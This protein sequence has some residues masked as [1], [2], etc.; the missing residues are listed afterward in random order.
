LFLRNQL[1]RDA[2]WSSMAHSLELRTPLVDA[3]LLSDLRLCHSRFAG[4]RGKQMLAQSPAKPLPR[5]V[6]HRTKTGFN[7]PM[8]RWIAEM[9][10]SSEAARRLRSLDGFRTPW[11]R[12]WAIALLDGSFASAGVSAL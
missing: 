11:A 8:T 1:L 7:I 10:E 9:V 2:D 4:K 5:D 12:Q 6:V 3:K